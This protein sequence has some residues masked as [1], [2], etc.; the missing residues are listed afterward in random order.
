MPKN[1]I[2]SIFLLLLIAATIL[3]MVIASHIQPNLKDKPSNMSLYQSQAKKICTMLDNSYA[4]LKKGQ[5]KQAYTISEN[6]YWD[7]YD[8]ILE[9]KYRPDATPA[10]IFGVEGQFH[11]LSAQI[12]LNNPNQL[13][14]IHHRIKNLCLEVNKEANYITKNG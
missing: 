11:E 12:K 10:Y 9:I 4:I 3:C 5:P 8:N 13:P 7:V 1:K 14:D 2:I 6:A